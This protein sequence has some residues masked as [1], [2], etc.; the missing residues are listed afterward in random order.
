M[1]AIIRS[2]FANTFILLVFCTV[3]LM[4]T[5]P[6]KAQDLALAATAPQTAR[7]QWAESVIERRFGLVLGRHARALAEAEKDCRAGE[8][9]ACRLADWRSFLAEIDGASEADQLYR[10]HSYINV[11]RYVSDERNWHRRDYWATPQQLLSRGGDCEDYVVAKYLSLR[12]LGIPAERMRIVVVYDRRRE[13]DHAVL[14]VSGDD[15]TF[16]LDN[17]YRRVLTWDRLADRYEPY[18]SLNE[19]AVWI[20]KTRI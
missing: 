12:A 8:H 10:V 20:H 16:I 15:R 7:L 4:L 6:S 2:R 17:R 3:L 9:A 14:A 18:Y 11:A 19:S 13:V 1:Y 5:V